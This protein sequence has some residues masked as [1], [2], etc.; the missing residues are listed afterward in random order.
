MNLTNRIELRNKIID[1]LKDLKCRE[2]DER[3]ENYNYGIDVCI[4]AIEEI[5][6]NCEVVE[7]KMQLEKEKLQKDYDDL[8][9][10]HENLTHEWV[11]LKKELKALHGDYDD[12]LKNYNELVV[13][14]NNLY[15]E[16]YEEDY[17]E[18]D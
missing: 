7:D 9:E 12:L 5:F 1:T 6:K 11:R 17:I 16:L 15:T 14:F 4:S 2:Y 10:G 8:Y 18:D 13:K 3:D